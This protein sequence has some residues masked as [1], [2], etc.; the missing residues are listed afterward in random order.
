MKDKLKIAEKWHHQF[1]HQSSVRN[2]VVTDSLKKKFHKIFSIYD[3]CIKY[4]KVE[5]KPVVSFPLAT[6][7][8]ETVVIDI[9]EIN[10][11]VL[12]FNHAMWYSVAA[13]LK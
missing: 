6:R 4:K 11:K 8:N 13:K 5:P 7:F 2:A 12:H 9:K 1:S 10:L 3:F